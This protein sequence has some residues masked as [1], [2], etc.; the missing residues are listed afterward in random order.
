MRDVI[1]P[2]LI[3]KTSYFTSNSNIHNNRVNSRI[4]NSVENVVASGTLI[5][6]WC[7][8]WSFSNRGF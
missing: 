7:G 4:E 2:Q 5:C 8:I 3:F 1:K 6:T